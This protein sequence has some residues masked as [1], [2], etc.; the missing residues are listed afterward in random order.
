M[1]QTRVSAGRFKMVPRKSL[2]Q[3]SKFIQGAVSLGS[4]LLH[5]KFPCLLQLLCLS[6]H[7]LREGRSKKFYHYAGSGK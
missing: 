6:F 7:G 1:R 2:M 5:V 4:K 3:Q